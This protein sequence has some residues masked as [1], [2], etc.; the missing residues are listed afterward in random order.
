MI[1]CN[2]ISRR[3]RWGGPPSRPEPTAPGTSPLP[4][5]ESGLGGGSLTHGDGIPTALAGA[6][7][8]TRRHTPAAASR[9]SPASPRTHAGY[10]HVGKL[11]DNVPAYA[12]SLPLILANS[13]QKA[14]ALRPGCRPSF[15]PGDFETDFST[16]NSAVQGWRTGPDRL[17]VE[18][19]RRA[20]RHRAAK[21][22]PWFLGRCTDA[23][24]AA[25]PAPSTRC[26]LCCC[27]GRSRRLE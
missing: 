24:E 20:G 6:A 11:E 1:D 27:N 9:P 23:G 14:M 8:L 12:T 26:R 13:A 18:G 19:D 10:G 3:R 7:S 21:A 5:A 16:P 25:A 22:P 15:L 2:D 17:R 4:I